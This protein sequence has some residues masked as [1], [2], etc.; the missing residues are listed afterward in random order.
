MLLP[1]CLLTLLG[2][3]LCLLAATATLKLLLVRDLIAL[4]AGVLGDVSQSLTFLQP[5]L[6][7]DLDV[8]LVSETDPAKTS[9]DIYCSHISSKS[10][11]KVFVLSGPAPRSDWRS[12]ASRDLIEEGLQ[13]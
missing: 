1:V 13:Q 10:L 8:L 11:G 2:A 4:P 3:V 12:E 6:V 7:L 9:A 5:Q